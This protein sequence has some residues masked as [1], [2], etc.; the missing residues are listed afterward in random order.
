[1]ASDLYTLEDAESHIAQLRGQVDRLSEILILGNSFV[2]ASQPGAAAIYATGGQPQ[3]VNPQGMAMGLSGAQLADTSTTTVTAS[4]MQNLT[5]GWPILAG[6][7]V[8]GAIYRVTAFGSGTW[9]STGTK[10]SFQGLLGSATNLGG[11]TISQGAFPVS[12]GFRWNATVTVVC[13]TTGS[14][15]TWTGIV[16]GSINESPNDSGLFTAATNAL[17]FNGA[18]GA[19]ALTTVATQNL[20]LQATWANSTFSATITSNCSFFER[21]A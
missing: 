16:S 1:M 15:G 3:Y 9:G 10:L 14:G 17:P 19:Q 18:S 5:A 12:T 20:Q 8:P 6:D 13:L 2:P 7:A 21:L 4:S 11:D